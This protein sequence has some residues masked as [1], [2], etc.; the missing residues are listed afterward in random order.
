MRVS[1]P[2]LNLGAVWGLLRSV[3]LSSAGLGTRY[4]PGGVIDH[5]D[6]IENLSLLPPILLVRVY[7]PLSLVMLNGLYHRFTCVYH[8]SF[9]ALTRCCGYR[10]G[11]LLPGQWVT[12]VAHFPQNVACGTT[13][14]RSSGIDSQH[15]I[16]SHLIVWDFNS[17]L[18]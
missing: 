8:A 9:L 18:P 11:S 15:G 13:A 6:S 7:Q 16:V 10:E 17:R 4:R 14:L 1:V 12:Y 2:N 3:E 5:G